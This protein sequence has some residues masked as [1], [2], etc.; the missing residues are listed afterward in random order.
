MSNAGFGLF[1]EEHEAFRRTVRR[2]V[3]ERLV[4]HAAAW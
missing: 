2:W 3:E 4:P 1:T